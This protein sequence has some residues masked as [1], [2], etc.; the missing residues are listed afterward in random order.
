MTDISLILM[1]AAENCIGVGSQFHDISLLML[2]MKIF[3]D[4]EGR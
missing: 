3:L 1:V 2:G 4:F